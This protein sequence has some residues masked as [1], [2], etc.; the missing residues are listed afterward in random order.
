MKN[1]TCSVKSS[2][3]YAVASITVTTALVLAQPLNAIKAYAAVNQ[4]EWTKHEELDPLGGFYTSAATSANGNHL[5]LSAADGGSGSELSPLYI[6]DNY[7]ASWDNVADLIDPTI[8]NW[9]TSV[10]VSNDGQVMVA[11]SNDGTDTDDD[12]NTPGKLF[13]S[14]TGGNSWDSITPMGDDDWRQIVVSGDGSSVAAVRWGS[15][16]VYCLSSRS[17]RAE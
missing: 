15:G 14:K 2:N 17:T 13:I 6:S 7:G 5:M 9:W 3:K 10:D 4:Y 8:R 1:L 11:S 16:D 12:S